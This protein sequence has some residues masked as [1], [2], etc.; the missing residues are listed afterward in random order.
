MLK[1]ATTSSPG[2]VVVTEGASK[3]RLPQVKAPLCESIG[4]I[5]S[6][7]LTSRIDPT[8]DTDRASAHE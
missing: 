8:A 2:V 7:P 5:A 1:K 6:A 3:D 4:A